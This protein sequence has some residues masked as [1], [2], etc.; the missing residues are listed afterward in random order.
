MPLLQKKHEVFYNTKTKVYRTGATST[1][2][3]QNYIFR[4]TSAEDV[5]KRQDELTLCA[6]RKK[7]TLH[8]G[9]TT[10]DARR[11]TAQN[12]YF[13]QL[14]KSISNHAPIYQNP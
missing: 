9:G 1:T 13:V 2:Y 8:T 7:H 12:C 11:S 14:N 5:Q 4:D 10:R 6:Q 3:C